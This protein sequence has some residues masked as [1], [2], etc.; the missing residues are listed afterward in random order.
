MGAGIDNI[1]FSILKCVKS[2][3]QSLWKKKIYE[4]ITDN[5]HILPLQQNVSAQTIGRRIDIL[6]D[7]N[8]LE[9]SVT[10]S[11]DVDR[12]LIIG[13]QITE[14]GE[15]ILEEK[16]ETLLKSIIGRELFSEE[17][18]PIEKE[19][20]ETLIHDEFSAGLSV[21][22]STSGYNREQLLLLLAMYFIEQ[23]ATTAFTQ[24]QLQHLHTLVR[25][26]H[27]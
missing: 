4:H 19:A 14:K 7:K 3:E 13:Y 24:E 12:H 17:K 15:R 8:L 5:L 11:E 20:L 22:Q 9:S 6:T 16:R 1:D 25:E 26:N 23:D 21:N 27:L 2:S 10:S 18:F